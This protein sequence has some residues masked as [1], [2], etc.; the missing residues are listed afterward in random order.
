[1]RARAI[2]VAALVSLVGTAC[3]ASHDD[4]RWEPPPPPPP[5]TPPS[6][7]GVDIPEW[8]PLGPTGS[9]RVRVTDDERLSRL[10]ATFRRV[11]RRTL[12]GASGEVSLTGPELGE[13]MGTLTLVACDAANACVERRVTDLLVDT[14]P[15]EAT[16]ERA[17]VSPHLDGIDG[18]VAVWAADGWV[19]GSVELSFKGK[20]LRHELPNVYPPTLGREWDVSRVAFDAKELPEGAGDATV[21]VRDAAGNARTEV[22]PLRIDGTP[23]TVAITEPANGATVGTSFDV[24]ITAADDDPEPPVVELWVGGARVLE[25]AAPLGKV[26]VDA[27]TLPPGTTELRATARDAAG[28]RSPAARVTVNVTGTGP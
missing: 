3:S 2:A 26:T 7:Q 9:V 23:P 22:F 19:L 25:A 8:P 20:T 17:A 1:M 4:L 15:P 28:N 14:T 24:S 13:G 6:I 27:S 21:V 12:D 16:L 5:P 10:T 18:Q 11:V